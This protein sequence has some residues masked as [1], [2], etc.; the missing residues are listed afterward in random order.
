MSSK[1]PQHPTLQPHFTDVTVNLTMPL[2]DRLNIHN[3]ILELGN[4]EGLY[5]PRI[6][7]DKEGKEFT[8]TFCNRGAIMFNRLAGINSPLLS[9]EHHS[10]PI[11]ENV[12]KDQFNANTIYKNILREA[13]RPDGQVIKLPDSLAQLVSNRGYLDLTFPGL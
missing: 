6:Y 2:E 7:K 8:S 9:S 5:R 1:W 13:D 11:L 12:A 10:G 3:E 4:K